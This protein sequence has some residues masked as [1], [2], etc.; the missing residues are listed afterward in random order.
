MAPYEDRRKTEDD[1]RRLKQTALGCVYRAFGLVNGKAWITHLLSCKLKSFDIFYQ[2]PYEIE[3][4]GENQY[5]LRELI[6]L[7]KM[8][9]V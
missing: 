9:Q 6:K 2:K 1:S 3:L 8:Y 5:I 7:L 4:A